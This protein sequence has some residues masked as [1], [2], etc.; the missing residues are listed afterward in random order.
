[1]I[2][3]IFHGKNWK[4]AG[5]K[6]W[7]DDEFEGELN[8]PVGVLQLNGELHQVHP[9]ED[10]F[11]AVKE[12]KEEPVRT[13]YQ[14]NAAGGNINTRITAGSPEEARNRFIQLCESWGV[15]GT[16]SVRVGTGPLEKLHSFHKKHET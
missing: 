4:L 11:L 1:M 13:I 10:S 14:I 3:K 9:H 15:N 6:K 2:V 16:L 5:E 7:Q 8:D 12:V